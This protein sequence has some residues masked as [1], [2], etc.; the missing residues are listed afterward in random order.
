MTGASGFL[1]E[2]LLRFLGA[3]GVNVW[4]TYHHRRPNPEVLAADRT[5]AVDLGDHASLVRALTVATPRLVIHTAAMTDVGACEKDPA[6][7]EKVN[8]GGTTR[9]VDALMDAT[10]GARLVHVSTDLVFDGEHAPYGPE[11]SAH[12]LSVYG[13]SK[14]AAER[15]AVAYPRAV[16]VRTALLYGPP[17]LHKASFVGWMEK[18]LRA[19]E[20]LPLFEDEHRTPVHVDDAAAALWALGR[21]ATT[22]ITVLGGP[23]RVDR[24]TMGLRL[25]DALGFGG[26]LL[27]P[28]LRAASPAAALRPRDVSLA[29]GPVWASLGLAPQS[30]DEG[31]AAMTGKR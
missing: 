26:E 4:G 21:A 5:L 11:A 19:G 16:V 28:C 3:R 24:F 27:R 7:A 2:H 1:G 17:A 12:P 8:H 9:L 22:G 6:A 29:S 13:H 20:P 31:L 18:T 10:P 15:A 23:Q 14:L 30:F 25:V